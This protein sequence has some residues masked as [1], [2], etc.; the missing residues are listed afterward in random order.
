M[1]HHDRG[2]EMVKSGMV[3]VF[4]AIVTLLALPVHAGEE[5]PRQ[6]MLNNEQA[7]KA[8]VSEV[9]EL[10]MT[11]VNKSGRERVRRVEFVLDDSDPRLRR[12]YLRFMSPANVRGTAF[13][14]LEH[15][16]RDNDRWLYLPALRKTRRISG[17]AKTDSFVGTDFSFEDFEILDGEVGGRNYKY[18]LLGE[19]EFRGEK[20]WLIKAV[21]ATSVASENTGYGERRMWVEQEHYHVLFTEYYDHDLKLIKQME[22]SDLTLVPDGKGG[23]VRPHKLVMKNLMTEHTTIIKFENFV[24]NNPLDKNMFTRDYLSRGMF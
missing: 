5:D 2:M 3:V 24:L 4:G 7:R 15:E 9:A 21:P 18:T 16:G 20:C 17:S 23:E 11:L 8:D 13:V 12:S 6:I 1:R 22:A 10:T 14:Q 19:E